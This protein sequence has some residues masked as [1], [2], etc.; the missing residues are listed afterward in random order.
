MF[1]NIIGFALCISIYRLLSYSLRSLL[2]LK[3]SKNWF[4]LKK[5]FSILTK[6]IEQMFRC[7]SKDK[8]LREYAKTLRKSRNLLK[9]RFMSFEAWQT[10]IRTKQSIFYKRKCQRNPHWKFQLSIFKRSRK[11]NKFP[12]KHYGLTGHWLTKWIFG[13]IKIMDNFICFRPRHSYFSSLAYIL[14]L[15]QLV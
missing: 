9:M 15:V 10:D 7:H 12:Q 3:S 5:F 6:A 11:K 13:L 14:L 2:K 4:S 1:L 8:K